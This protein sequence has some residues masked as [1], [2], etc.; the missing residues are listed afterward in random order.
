[1][2]EI[3]DLSRQFRVLN[4]REG[5]KGAAKD[6]FSRNY[7]IV[8]AVKDVNMTIED[9]EIIGYVG[10]NG[11]GKSTTIKM[12]CGILQPSSGSIRVNGRDPFADR[13]EH[14]RRLGVVFGQRTQLWWNLPV[15]ES[16]RVLKDIYFVDDANYK[17]N[18]QMFEDLVHIDE[19]YSKTV[20]QMSLGQRMLCEVTAAF[21]HD[22]ELV[23]LD[24]PTIGLDVAVKDSIRKLIRS[25]NEEKKATILL[26]SHDTSD[27]ESLCRR[28]AVIDK[29]TL[30]FDG[31]LGNLRNMFGNRRV[32]R[33]DMETGARTVDEIRTLMQMNFPEGALEVQTGNDGEIM[34]Y[35]DEAIRPLVGVVD[36]AVKNLSFDNISIEQTGLEEIIKKIYEGGKTNEKISGD[37]GEQDQ[38][39]SDVS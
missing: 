15:R 1:M 5:L 17:R 37:I 4:R 34:I 23:L 28:V 36:F 19:L 30:I 39:R 10:P 24:E 29:G 16:F 20:R 9:G 12:L 38:G 3:K 31:E 35:V 14:M 33:L 27:I 7:R 11:A 13:M 6:L 2:I 21:M 26:T 18:M 25:L 8:D 22:P 32:I